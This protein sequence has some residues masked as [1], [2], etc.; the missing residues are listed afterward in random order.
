[1]PLPLDNLL[2]VTYLAAADFAARARAFG[3]DVCGLEE[4]ELTAHLA[5]ASRA[6][7]AP[8]PSWQP[9]RPA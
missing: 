2:G 3:A 6:V 7:E 5:L 1:M 8:G 9:W 4:E